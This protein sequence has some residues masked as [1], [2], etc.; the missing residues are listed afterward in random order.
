MSLAVLSQNLSNSHPHVR[1]Q[2]AVTIYLRFLAFFLAALLV[3]AFFAGGALGASV[4]PCSSLFVLLPVLS[5]V[6]CPPG[7]SAAEMNRLAASLFTFID[8]SFFSLSAATFFNL[9]I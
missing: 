2:L 6:G 7:A 5:A 3:L 1:A 4:L 9:C 8:E